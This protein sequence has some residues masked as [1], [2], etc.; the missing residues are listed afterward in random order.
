MLTRMTATWLFLVGLCVGGAR[1]GD[2]VQPLDGE[3]IAA[4]WKERQDKVQSA[5]FEITKTLYYPRGAYSKYVPNFRQ[6]PDGV[7][8]APDKEP[9]PTADYRITLTGRM[10]IDGV[11]IRHD[12]YSCQCNRA[13][14]EFYSRKEQTAFDG[15]YFRTIN[16]TRSGAD[17]GAVRK[18]S[19]YHDANLI[20]ISA[21]LNSIRGGAKGLYIIDVR[22]I[23]PTG[24]RSMIDGTECLEYSQR[25]SNSKATRHVWLAPGQG[26]QLLRDVVAV[27]ESD[28]SEKREIRY[29]SDPVVGWI[30]ATWEYVR[31]ERGELLIQSRCKLDTYSLN[32]PIQ[33]EEFVLTFPKRMNVMDEDASGGAAVGI[34]QEDGRLRPDDGR[35]A[36]YL[37]GIEMPWWQKFIRPIVYALIVLTVGILAWRVVMRYRRLRAIPPAR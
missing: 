35:P 3:A 5:T 11:K 24:R 8:I 28:K 33:A 37:P 2:Q 7:I 21:L 10:V 23:S 26:W 14:G 9:L 19:W 6:T 13:R 30:P 22:T 29:K 4:I 34:V 25:Q 18:A 27:P 36:Y 16:G 1:A 15:E 17:E 32:K 12:Y 31:I 20:S